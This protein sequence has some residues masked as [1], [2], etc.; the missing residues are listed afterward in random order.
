MM[1]AFVWLSLTAILAIA[2]FGQSTE[3]PG[4]FEIADIHASPRTNTLVMRTTTRPGRYELDNAS[5][6][7]L[8]RTAYAFDADKIVG[9]PTWLEY[10][11]FD[12]IA[13][14]P[15]KMPDP[16]TLKLML[17]SLLADRFK[18]VVH[19]DT[20]PVTGWVL[21]MGKGKHKLK[22]S[23][24][25]GETGCK[26]QSQTSTPLQV[27]GGVLNIPTRSYSCHNITI[28]AFAD[29]LR[30]MAPGDVTNAVVDSTGLKGAWDMPEHH[31]GAVC[32]TAANLRSERRS[33][34]G[35]RWNRPRWSLGFFVHVQSRNPEPD[36]R[37]ARSTAARRHS[38]RARSG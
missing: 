1:R 2:A 32:G 31:D 4:A 7:D 3:T 14:T 37:G 26:L 13:Q 36:R 35:V 21:T 19:K 33:L 28:E 38:R 29:A 9:G 15:S 30:G 27:S 22:E 34:S 8:I 24:G 5:M 12:V 18:L 6:L 17:Q 25:K 20:Q 16:E 11:R 23:D 10:H